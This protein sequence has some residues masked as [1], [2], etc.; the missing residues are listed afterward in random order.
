MNEFIFW[1]L[2]AGLFLLP[3]YLHF[4]VF[5]RFLRAKKY[6]IYF[7]L[8]VAIVFVFGYLVESV[9]LIKDDVVVSN[10]AFSILLLLIFST[11]TK[12][13][14]EGMSA[15]RRLA[16][17]EVARS[18]A[19]L[20]SLKT[21]VNPHFLF[22]SLNNIYGLLMEDVEKAGS[23]LLTL[24]GLM[25]YLIY[26]GSQP[27][28]SLEEEVNFIEDYVA[29]ER[30]RL[31]EKCR[32][33]MQ[34]H[35]DFSEKKLP[36]FMLIPFVE[37]AFKHGSYSTVE[38]SFIKIDIQLQ[39]SLLSFEIEN[40]FKT[41]KEQHVGGLG[42]ANVKQRLALEMADRYTLGLHKMEDVFTVKLNLQL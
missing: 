42:I 5:N 28:V 31:G 32:I 36:P 40:S 38:E 17:I 14:F 11:T 13:L 30:L 10:G 16:Q 21:Q 24:S 6:L 4:L 27:N 20:D 25:R 8:L 23:S 26:S 15:K 18:K 22:N 39:D 7:P 3:I 35:G 19:E 2:F 29:M 41:K 34:K 1:I 12:L 9:K 37:N 33:Q